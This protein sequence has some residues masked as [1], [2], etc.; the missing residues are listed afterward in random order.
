MK[1]LYI[2][3]T[4]TSISPAS[5]FR[6]AFAITSVS[7]V[8]VCMERQTQYSETTQRVKL[9]TSQMVCSPKLMLLPLPWLSS[10]PR[11]TRQ[12]VYNAIPATNLSVKLNM[13]FD[14]R[15][16]LIRK[17]QICFCSCIAKEILSFCVI[18]FHLV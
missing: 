11:R 4:H 14:I 17:I 6:K 8:N 16:L 2:L 9:K 13:H 7:G 18:N 3:T 15:H 10:Q 1:Y 5:D 12:F